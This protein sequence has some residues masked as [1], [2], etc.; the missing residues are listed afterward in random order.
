MK[1]FLLTSFATL[2]VATLGLTSPANAAPA[3]PS[4]VDATIEHL[5]S[6]GY[7]VI[8][9]RFGNLQREQCTIAAVRPGQIYSRTDSGAPGAGD[10]LVT[11]VLSKTVY[12][13]LSC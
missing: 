11:T 9:S 1:K 4:S 10:D 3:D 8:V 12:V 13:E 5:Q 2:A 7:G 6:G